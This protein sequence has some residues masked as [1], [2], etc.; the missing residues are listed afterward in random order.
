[1]DS[2]GM[3]DDEGIRNVAGDAKDVSRWQWRA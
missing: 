2:G 1:M 3:A